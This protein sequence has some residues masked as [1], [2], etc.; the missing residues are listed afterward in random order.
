MFAGSCATYE[1]LQVPVLRP[2]PVDI[3]QHSLIAVDR[4]TGDGSQE[5]A[6]ELVAALKRAR[7]PLTGKVD[8]EIVERGDVDR[9]VDDMRRYPKSNLGQSPDSALAKWQRARLHLTGTVHAHSVTEDVQCQERQDPKTGL[10]KFFVRRAQVRVD[11][12]IEAR[13]NENNTLFDQ[14]RLRDGAT[15]T[16]KAVDEGPASIDHASLLVAA[17]RKVIGAYLQ[18]VLPHREWVRVHLYRDSDLPPLEVGNGLAKTGDW[19]EALRSYRQAVHLAQGE[20]GELRYMGLH[21]SGVALLHLNR[22]GEAR[23]ALKEAYALSQDEPI[24]RQLQAVA[25]REQEYEELQRQSQRASAEP[26]R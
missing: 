26:G 16:T 4:F 23:Q 21:N 9:M 17:R 22:F 10:H 11:V 19:E 8:F 14:V 5:V 20:L 6:H 1:T 7:N 18:R 13:D 3:G 24:L 2:A 12:T 25:Q 15:A